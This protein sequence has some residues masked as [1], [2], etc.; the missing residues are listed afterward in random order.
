MMNYCSINKGSNATYKDRVAMKPHHRRRDS[1]LDLDMPH[2]S[3]VLVENLE[4]YF[5][6]TA[7][8]WRVTLK[9]EIKDYIHASFANVRV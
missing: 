8:N 4:M 5:C 9:G 2:T 1:T 6:T 7:E 3:T